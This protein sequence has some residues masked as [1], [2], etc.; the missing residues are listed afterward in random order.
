MNWTDSRQRTVPVT[1]SIRDRTICDGSLIACARTFATSG[2]TGGL[3]GI[4][5]KASAMASA[6]GCIR[7]QWKGADT[8]SI[9]ARFTPRNLASST[10]RSTAALV[11]DTTTCPPPLSL[12]AAQTPTSATSAAI[13][14]DIG[15]IEADHRRHGAGA[16]RNRFLHGAAANPQQ[17]RSVGDRQSTGCGKRR[18]F[19]ERVPRDKGGVALEIDAGLRLKTRNAASDTAI[20]AGCAFSVSVSVSAGPFQMSSLSFSPRAASTSSKTRRAAG[21]LRRELLPMP[22]A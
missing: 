5:A 7:R 1:C 14:S 20:S 6:A 13:A 16:D 9:I 17:S 8:G 2:T 3:T 19:A 4:L 15:K 10:A 21:R 18:I 12:A 22:T 11:P